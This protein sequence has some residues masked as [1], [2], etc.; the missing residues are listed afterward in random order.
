M[1]I[2][3]MRLDRG[4]SQEQLAGMAGISTRTLQR[5]ERGAPASTETLKCLAS[6]FETDFN[7]LKEEPPMAQTSPTTPNQTDLEREAL[8]YVRDIKAF[9]THLFTFALIVVFLAGINFWVTPGY[10]WVLWVIGGWGVGII[11]HGFS[12]FEVFNLFGPDWE[13]KQVEKRLRQSD[14]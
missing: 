6:V 10:P 12:V 11:S 4:W 3:K 1:L 13:R 8:E 5:I 2:R 14:K 9:Y 7:T